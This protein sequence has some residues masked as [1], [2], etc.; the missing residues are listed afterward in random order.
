METLAEVMRVEAAS[1]FKTEFS[2]VFKGLD[3]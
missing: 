1:D 3:I 2:F